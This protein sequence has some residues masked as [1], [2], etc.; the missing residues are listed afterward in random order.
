M[1]WKK[2]WP[3]ARLEDEVAEEGAIP[4]RFVIAKVART[5]ACRY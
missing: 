3:W 1:V 2:V 4:L 5:Y